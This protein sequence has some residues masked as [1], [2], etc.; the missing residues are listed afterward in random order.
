MPDHQLI[1]PCHGTVEAAKSIE[2][3]PGLQTGT[4]PSMALGSLRKVLRP[5]G[6]GKGVGKSPR[7]VQA[8]G[9]AF[10]PV[11]AVS[12]CDRS[13]ERLQHERFHIGLLPL[14]FSSRCW[15]RYVW[16]QH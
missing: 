14:L 15:S 8:K 12:K 4:Q 6:L 5:L 3:F 1:G 7:Q 9:W 16:P 13:E 2:G 11:A 10:Q